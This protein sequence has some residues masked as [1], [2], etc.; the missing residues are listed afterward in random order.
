MPPQDTSQKRSVSGLSLTLT[1]DAS[2]TD[3]FEAI[4]T[5]SGIAAWWTSLVSGTGTPGNEFQLGF[6]GLEEIIRIRVDEAKRPR[7]V[8]W[9]V[10][11]H[12]GLPDW[13]GT[14]IAF[15]L[16]ELGPRR[17]ILQFR[18]NGLVPQLAC[19]GDCRAGWSHFLDSLAN[20]AAG[21][22]GSPYGV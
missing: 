13:D 8:R 19:Y 16:S 4:A 20:V 18:H 2:A 6:E 22:P 11:R 1:I 3:T 15:D 10:L 17:T 21:R 14:N 12:T 9:T 7:M 5:R